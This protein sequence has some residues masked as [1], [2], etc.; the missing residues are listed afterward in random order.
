MYALLNYSCEHLDMNWNS[1]TFIT[2]P[3]IWELLCKVK[4]IT[5][6]SKCIFCPNMHCFGV[7][8]YIT[9]NVP[10]FDHLQLSTGECDEAFQQ[11]QDEIQPWVQLCSA[12]LSSQ[13]QNTRA[14]DV[15]RCWGGNTLKVSL[16]YSLWLGATCSLVKGLEWQPHRLYWKKLCGTTKIFPQAK[17]QESW[18]NTYTWDFIYIHTYVHIYTHMKLHTYILRCFWFLS[19]FW[20]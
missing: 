12:V 13:D 8:A 7:K 2:I 19:G 4:E 11:E 3:K 9:A 17:E 5:Q 15:M 10:V 14:R 6:V 1:M 18:G 20:C 16:N